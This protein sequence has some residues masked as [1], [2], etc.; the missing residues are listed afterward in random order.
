MLQVTICA[1]ASHVAAYLE[2]DRTND[3]AQV[4]LCLDKAA[5]KLTTDLVGNSLRDMDLHEIIHRDRRSTDA[6][7]LRNSQLCISFQCD[8]IPRRIPAHSSISL[9]VS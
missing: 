3:S 4:G 6:G 1:R 9:M 8:N 2:A 5:D 7:K